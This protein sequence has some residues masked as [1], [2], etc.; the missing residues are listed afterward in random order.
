MSDDTA[1]LNPGDQQWLLH[2][3]VVAGIVSA[4][5]RFVPIPFV[6]DVIQERCHRRIIGKTLAVHGQEHRLSDFEPFLNSSDGCL[7]GCLVSV[8]KVPI[9]LLLFP[10]R[11]FIAIVTS[12]RGVPMEI[13]RSVLLG[14]TVNRQL[15]DGNTVTAADAAKMRLAF[16][17]A[18]TRMDL[19]VVR[20][21]ISDALQQVSS[22]KSSALGSARKV[23]KSDE[24]T[25][26]VMAE[27]GH[28]QSGAAEVQ[29]A[30]QRPEILALFAEFDARFD[31]ALADLQS[32]NPAV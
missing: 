7:S 10:F 17:K 25:A 8:A 21:V 4:A 32:Q 15:A 31:A 16:R 5:A 24:S 3:W 28:V 6:D 11:K 20:A 19:H 30:L 27:S 13:T 2:H 9:K 14:R 29:S 12:V 22:W 1:A 18:F 26:A 23:A